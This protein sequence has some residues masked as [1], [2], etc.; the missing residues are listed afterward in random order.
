MTATANRN[1]H[2]GA[3]TDATSRKTTSH[4]AYTESSLSAVLTRESAHGAPTECTSPRMF[5]TKPAM[6][7][8]VGESSES[9]RSADHGVT[10]SSDG[11]SLDRRVGRCAAGAA[12]ASAAAD[13]IYKTSDQSSDT[14]S[15]SESEHRRGLEHSKM[16]ARTA[17]RLASIAP[18]GSRSERGNEHDHPVDSA[19]HPAPLAAAAPWLSP[20][21]SHLPPNSSSPKSLATV[22]SAVGKVGTPAPAP[23]APPPPPAAPP[24]QQHESQHRH[25]PPLRKG[26][27][28]IEEEMYT[29]AIIREFERGM[30]DCAP[31]TTLRSYL[32]EKLHCD[33]MRITKKFAGDASIGKRVFTPCKHTAET[34]V[35]IA[36]VRSE[37]HDMARRF[38][39]HLQRSNFSYGSAGGV[40]SKQRRSSSSNLH[41]VAPSPA[42]SLQA[43]SK[44]T[45]QQ[46]Q[47]KY[48]SMPGATM[49]NNNHHHLSNSV[50]GN[51]GPLSKGGTY[52][53]QQ[54]VPTP[55]SYRRGDETLKSVSSGLDIRGF[56][57]PVVVDHTGA[58][59]ATRRGFEDA[60]APARHRSFDAASE[61]DLQ[62]GVP[63]GY[64][65]QQSSSM[66][67]P[68]GST[69]NYLGAV[70]ADD[71]DYGSGQGASAAFAPRPTSKRYRKNLNTSN[72]FRL[73]AESSQPGLSHQISQYPHPTPIRDTPSPLAT[74]QSLA[75]PRHI[76]AAKEEDSRLLL[77]FF[78]TVHERCGDDD[79]RRQQEQQQDSQPAADGDDSRFRKRTRASLQQEK[80]RQSQQQAMA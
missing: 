53:H 3:P 27:W 29:S 68:A 24:Q 10:V 8:M 31:G 5:H 23:P 12:S 11:E 65:R 58:L 74:T 71:M 6:P 67:A 62:S 48:A 79:A 44:A 51:G 36:R 49:A 61:P 60:P 78:V 25:P 7:R 18:R 4:D 15:R 54:H 69:G 28:T 22:P 63:P 9:A 77:D 1:A 34:A 14:S 57:S 42:A 50:V 37:L 41:L 13:P 56:D 75:S 40:S 16:G 19:W 39:S 73:P 72:N 38:L 35:E 33:P 59:V 52:V 47:H 66:G 26:K 32:S 45:L 30:L 21:P 55:N 20:P 64:G 17:A 46:Q 70:L 2:T 43:S 80:Q 76:D